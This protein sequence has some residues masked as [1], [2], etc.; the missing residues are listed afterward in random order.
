[1]AWFGIFL[2]GVIFVFSVPVDSGTGMLVAVVLFFASCAGGLIHYGR[3]FSHSVDQIDEWI[4]FGRPLNAEMRRTQV[5]ATN[6]L[7]RCNRLKAREV[8]LNQTS[9]RIS[10]RRAW[11]RFDRQKRALNDEGE[12]L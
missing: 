8:E 2:S 9:T 6:W 10:H 11:A 7:E 4:S 12:R 1:M 5:Q 3:M